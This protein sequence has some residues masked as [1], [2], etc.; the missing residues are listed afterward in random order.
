MG[1]QLLINFI[2]FSFHRFSFFYWDKRE[3]ASIFLE[4]IFVYFQTLELH[5]GFSINECISD[6]QAGLR[7]WTCFL[8]G[9]HAPSESVFL[10]GF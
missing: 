8:D 2:L 9:L 10:R 4:N 1:E 5:F 6:V 3:V 7:P